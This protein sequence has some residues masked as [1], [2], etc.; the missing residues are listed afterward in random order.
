MICAGV[1]PADDGPP[2]GTP[3]L[4]I[5]IAGAAIL[6]GVLV[7]QNTAPVEIAISAIVVFALVACWYSDMVCGIL[8]DAFTL[9]PLGAVLLIA[10]VERN[11]AILIAAGVAFVPFAI[12]SYLTKGIGMGWG[13]TKLVT[14]CGAALGA[15]T[16]IVAMA[17]ASGAAVIAHRVTGGKRGPI[18]LAPYIAVFTA[19]MLPWGVTH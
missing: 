12:V 7:W 9:A 2:R 16:V 13:D 3:P 8:P 10:I 5:I 19:L 11:W 17:F 6:G 15:P 1:T 4:A 18:A 14:L